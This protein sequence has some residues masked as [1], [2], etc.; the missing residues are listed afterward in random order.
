[1]VKFKQIRIEEYGYWVQIRCRKSKKSGEKVGEISL[2]K[3]IPEKIDVMVNEDIN[4]MQKKGDSKKEYKS[5]VKLNNINLPIKKGEVIGRLLVK[6]GNEVIKEVDLKSNQDMQKR[7][8]FDMW[9]NI[10]K[11]M[12]TGDLIN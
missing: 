10:L 1:M 8:F 3:A 7:S 4:I 9:G 11:S 6:D 2:D 12:F 5:E